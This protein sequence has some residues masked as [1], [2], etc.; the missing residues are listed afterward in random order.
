MKFLLSAGSALLAL[1]AVANNPAIKKGE[2][3]WVDTIF[4]LMEKVD[5]IHSRPR[6]RNR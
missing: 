6:K 5:R 4:E 3:K 1:E 2:D